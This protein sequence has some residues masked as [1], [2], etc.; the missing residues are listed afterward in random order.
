MPIL[1]RLWHRTSKA[2]FRARC[3]VR[4]HAFEYCPRVARRD[5]HYRRH[6][7]HKCTRC[8]KTV[9]IAVASPFPRDPL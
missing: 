7:A 5:D 4:G 3:V 9:W 6:P 8:G 2:Y 1:G